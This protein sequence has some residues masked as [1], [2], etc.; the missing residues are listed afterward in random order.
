MTAKTR[1]DEL[2]FPLPPKNEYGCRPE[3]SRSFLD[4]F[5]LEAGL[6]TVVT[7]AAGNWM[8]DLVAAMRHK[9]QEECSDLAMFAV[10]GADLPGLIPSCIA[11]YPVWYFVLPRELAAVASKL[12]RAELTAYGGLTG[13]PWRNDVFIGLWTEDDT[14]LLNAGAEPK[15][16]AFAEGNANVQL[17]YDKGCVIVIFDCDGSLHLGA[18]A[19]GE[20]LL[21]D[22]QACRASSFQRPTRCYSSAYM[23]A[24]T[25]AVEAGLPDPEG[26]PAGGNFVARV[27]RLGRANDIGLEHDIKPKRNGR[28]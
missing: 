27:Y 4:N 28:E 26:P 20:N 12:P 19:V 22:L 15:L 3:A 10:L 14:A 2:A 21:V 8:P 24:R 16:L 13:D 18:L 1:G 23:Q 6:P 25:K 11:G 5:L 17:A 7:A 9:A